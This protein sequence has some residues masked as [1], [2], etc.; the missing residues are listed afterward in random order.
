ITRTPKSGWSDTPLVGPFAAA[1]GVPVGFDT[2]VNAAALAEG[3]WGAARG[4][5]SFIYLTLGTGIGGGAVADSRVAHRAC[6]APS[7]ASGL[8][9]EW[10]VVPWARA[11]GCT[12]SATTS[13]VISSSPG[14]PATR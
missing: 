11:G 7:S 5:S 12:G 3:R 1:F 2:D 8:G 10:A 4:L 9:Q 6:S 13:W 14:G